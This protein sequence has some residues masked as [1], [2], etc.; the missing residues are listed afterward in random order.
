MTATL[1]TVPQ[2]STILYLVQ[3]SPTPPSTSQQPTT[4]HF[5]HSDN[6]TMTLLYIPPQA[7]HTMGKNHK[8]TSLPIKTGFPN[9]PHHPPK[10]VN[11]PSSLPTP[12]RKYTKPPRYQFKEASQT[13]LTTTT[14]SPALPTFHVCQSFSLIQPSAS[15]THFLSFTHSLTPPRLRPHSS[16]TQPTPL[17]QMLEEARYILGPVFNWGPTTNSN[18][19][20]PLAGYSWDYLSYL[21]LYCTISVIVPIVSLLK[22]IPHEELLYPKK[23]EDEKM[24]M[25][26]PPYEMGMMVE[27]MQG[28][29]MNPLYSGMDI[30]IDSDEDTQQG[31]HHGYPVPHTH[32]S[33]HHS[34]EH[35]QHSYVVQPIHDIEHSD[36]DLIESFFVPQ[37]QHSDEDLHYSYPSPPSP[38]LQRSGEIIKPSQHVHPIRI[39]RHS[40][41]NSHQGHKFFPNYILRSRNHRRSN[42]K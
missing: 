5:P 7:T 20:A 8:P 25:V 37:R 4:H 2:P 40:R 39:S 12:L 15:L 34:D 24:E 30:G 27:A 28:N 26:M 17:Y 10:E 13:H 18:V 23:K 6:Q 14:I 33:Q 21:L 1:T 11:K 41:E 9:P 3:H 35:P 19:D 29:G 42:R 31:I 16:L 32:D 36:G 22:F 38:I